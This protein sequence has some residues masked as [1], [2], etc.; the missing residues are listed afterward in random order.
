M[1]IIICYKQAIPETH[2][3]GILDKEIKVMKERKVWD[4][5]DHPDF[6][7][8]RWV[9]TIKYDENNKIVDYVARKRDVDDGPDDCPRN[10]TEATAMG[11]ECLR[12][13]KSHKDCI[14]TR[15]RCL[16]DGLCGWS[17]VRPGKHS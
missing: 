4:L 15:K 6:L 1:V 11:R 8:N 12:K 13:C 10:R 5:V 14:S 3:N 2:L 16:C 7:E 17:C 9:Y